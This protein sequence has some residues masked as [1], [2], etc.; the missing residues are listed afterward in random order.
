VETN[1]LI[2][3]ERILKNKNKLCAYKKLCVFYN[4]CLKTFGSHLLNTLHKGDSDDDGNNS[5]NM[6]GGDKNFLVGGIK[7]QGSSGVFLCY[8]KMSS[9]LT[10]KRATVRSYLE[11]PLTL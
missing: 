10:F 7:C 9:W 6:L 3:E 4:S 11:Q 5:S 1:V 8:Q 2:K